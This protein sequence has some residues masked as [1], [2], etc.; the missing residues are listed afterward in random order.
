MNSRL[1]EC[2][3]RDF[4]WYIR[5]IFAYQKRRYG[6][7]LSPMWAWGQQPAIMF[8]FLFMITRFN[9]LKSP[10]NLLRT[11]LSVRI[12]QINHCAFCMD[13]NAH[14]FLAAHGA[15]EKIDFI[16][17]WPEHPEAFSEEERA[18]LAYAEAVT[19]ND[20]AGTARAIEALKGFFTDQEIVAITAWIGAQNLSS[21]FNDA[22]GI[23]MQRFCRVPHHGRS[24]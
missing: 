19:R 1:D 3:E 17:C 12:S 8:A 18:A 14:N 11:L 13:F 22:L 2:S 16:D 9:R 5:L 4:P 15:Q 7:V 20:D 6:Q 21:K 10:S 23:P 24:D